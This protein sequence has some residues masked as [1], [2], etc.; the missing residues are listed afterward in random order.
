MPMLTLICYLF[1]ENN[2]KLSQ[3]MYVRTAILYMYPLM[4]NRTIVKLVV[5]WGS[6]LVSSWMGN[7]MVSSWMGDPMVM[8]WLSGTWVMDLIFFLIF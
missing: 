7:P 8:K 4:P 6:P 1:A 5:G 2:I 3:H